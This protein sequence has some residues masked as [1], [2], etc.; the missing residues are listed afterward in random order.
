MEYQD[1][2]DNDN[3][4]ATK[5]EENDSVT[6]DERLET[7]SK[8]MKK[9]NKNQSSLSTLEDDWETCSDDC[10]CSSGYDPD[11]ESDER[12]SSRNLKGGDVES[13]EKLRRD[14]SHLPSSDAP[15][16][17]L[18]PQKRKPSSPIG[19]WEPVLEDDFESDHFEDDLES[20][21]SVQV[22]ASTLIDG[23]KSEA[24][25]LDLEFIADISSVNNRDSREFLQ[26]VSPGSSRAAA[27]V[28]PTMVR[29]QTVETSE[30]LE[31]KGDLE[32][33]EKDC[34]GGSYENLF[35]GVPPRSCKKRSTY[36]FNE[37]LEY[38]KERDK[39]ISKENVKIG[40]KNQMGENDGS[41][42]ES[43]VVEIQDSPVLRKSS[44]KRQG[45]VNKD[46]I[47]L[48]EYPV[49]KSDTVTVAIQDYVTLEDDTFLNDIIIDFYLTHLKHNILPS[50]D[51]GRVHIFSTMFYKAL[52]RL[53]KKNAKK[54]ASF[55]TDPALSTPE[56]RHRRV[57]GWTKR[58]D[59]FTKD[60][61]IFPICENSHWYLLLVV[62]P[63]LISLPVDSEERQLKG[64]P[65]VIVL[66]SLGRSNDRAVINIWL[67]LA[68]EWEKKYGGNEE[69]D[70]FN[71]YA[72]PFKSA[73]P[74]KPHQQ[75]GSDCG[76]YL[77][78]Y[79]EKIFSSVANFLQ[80]SLPDLTNWFTE[81]EVG[82]K[83]GEIAQLIKSLSSEQNPGKIIKIPNINFS[84]S[85]PN[86]SKENS[87]LM[88]EADEMSSE[89]VVEPQNDL[90]EEVDENVFV[91]LKSNGG[92]D[93]ESAMLPDSSSTVSQNQTN[94][95]LKKVVGQTIQQLSPNVRDSR[96]VNDVPTK[97]HLYINDD[98]ESEDSISSESD[99]N[100]DDIEARNSHKLIKRVKLSH[101]QDTESESVK[102]FNKFLF[103]GISSG[104]SDIFSQDENI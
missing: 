78:H 31:D 104:D 90:S 73:C 89:A 74:M 68:C 11:S 26:A 49:G 97:T 46:S 35:G 1:T 17:P 53:P 75:N 13:P 16:V 98:N 4:N 47:K 85:N 20:S 101:F 64:E 59:L 24:K 67:Y 12:K 103:E 94:L 81:E 71:F 39:V 3:E 32:T 56:K 29:N 79:V 34:E 57:A 99:D 10:D 9:S 63:G 88:E 36:K 87:K 102:M 7:T 33:M 50:E 15:P 38:L 91:S 80:P 82:L 61:L 55:E 6:D 25:R 37:T 23:R 83:R 43:I 86:K 44:R 95:M 72:G 14:V 69:A 76:I 30:S 77:L 60:L 5:D 2:V 41:D 8:L 66:D 19:N 70:A 52:L 93:S 42:N 62:K 92:S 58:M 27:E 84:P 28:H 48:C 51:R 40:L 100:H 45:S 22:L 65:F 18:I 96:G 21:L 54:V